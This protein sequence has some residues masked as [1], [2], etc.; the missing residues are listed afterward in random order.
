M[1]QEWDKRYR[2]TQHLYGS[3]ANVFIQ[4]I[5]Q[6]DVCLKNRRV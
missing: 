4:D 2:E 6:R 3:E 1:H 5:S